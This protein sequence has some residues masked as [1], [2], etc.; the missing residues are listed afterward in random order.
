M[1]TIDELAQAAAL[2]LAGETVASGRTNDAPDVRTVRYYAALGLLDPPCSFVR[3]KARY[4]EIHLLQLVAVKRLQQGGLSLADIQAQLTGAHRSRLRTIARLP[5][6]PTGPTAPLREDGGHF[7]RRR[8]RELEPVRAVRVA[9]GI[10]LL[11]DAP[12]SLSDA[13]AAALAAWLRARGIV[14]SEEQP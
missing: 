2:A 14:P 13:D 6:A 11:I 4:G 5:E 1:W 10:T 12:A 9:P 3:R 7:W 8:P